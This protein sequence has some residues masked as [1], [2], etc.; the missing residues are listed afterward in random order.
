MVPWQVRIALDP[1]EVGAIE[2]AMALEVPW[3]QWALRLPRVED[4]AAP[5]LLIEVPADSHAAAEHE[6][7]G[8]YARA[9]ERA[10]LPQTDPL[11]LGALTPIFADALHAR[12]LDEAEGHILTGRR[13]WGVVRAQTACEVYA[14]GALNRLAVGLHEDGRKEPYRLF[15]ALTFRDPSDRA[16]LRALTGVAIGEQSWWPAYRLHVERRHHIVHAG[17]LVSEDEARASLSAARSFIAF[18]QELWSRA[19]EGPQSGPAPHPPRE[20]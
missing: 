4:E 6:A 19:S 12:L 9:R 5:A 8:I 16:L 11:V 3:E 14:R 20:P 1:G 10:G 15:R 7:V 2:T 18:L 17:L 13:E